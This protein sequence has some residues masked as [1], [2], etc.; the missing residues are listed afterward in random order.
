METNK[1][2]N[3][4]FFKYI[5]RRLFLIFDVKMILIKLLHNFLIII[6]NKKLLLIF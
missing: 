3:Y 6:I 2:K 4:N 5:I 1:K